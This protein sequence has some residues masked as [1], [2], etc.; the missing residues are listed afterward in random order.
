MLRPSRLAILA[1]A[2]RCA[3]FKSTCTLSKVAVFASE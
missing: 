2:R 3:G 1:N